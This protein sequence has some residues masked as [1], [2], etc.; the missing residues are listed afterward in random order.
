M[1]SQLDYS[2]RDIICSFIEMDENIVK[3]D[4]WNIFVLANDMELT[5]VIQNIIIDW[6]Y[7]LSLISS[8]IYKVFS[9]NDML[10]KL[11]VL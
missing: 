9:E 3:R 5:T 11:W 8:R 2:P 7:K 6:F 4:E 1:Q 10:F